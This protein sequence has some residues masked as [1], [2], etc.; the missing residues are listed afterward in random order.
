[1]DDVERAAVLTQ[2]GMQQAVDVLLADGTV[3]AIRRLLPTDREA[4]VALHE[5]ASDES[6]R[7]RF[8]T[9]GRTAGKT[10]AEHLCDEAGRSSG[11]IAL[12]AFLADEL[13]A[14]APS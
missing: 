13:V 9:G 8:F 3:A 5:A 2:P 12:A 1:M 4:L 6:L 7:R 11:V 14:W 10:Y